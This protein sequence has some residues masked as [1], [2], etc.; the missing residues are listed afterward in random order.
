MSAQDVEQMIQSLPEPELRRFAEWW[1][2]H[3][4]ALLRAA[5]E[6]ESDA[7]KAELSRRRQEYRDHPERFVPMDDAALDR[8]F[9]EIENETT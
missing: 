3:R 4:P 1:E 8:M 2:L 9:D 6:V 7:V 5:P